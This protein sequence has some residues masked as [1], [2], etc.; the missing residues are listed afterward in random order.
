MTPYGV[1]AAL[2]ASGWFDTP[3][4]APARFHHDVAI[5]INAALQQIWNSSFGS[6]FARQEQS[7]STVNGT[8]SYGLNDGVQRVLG[9]VRC[10]GRHLIE[11]ESLAAFRDRAT[12][13]SL[14]ATET[15]PR[16]YHLQRVYVG[17]GSTDTEAM[18]LS[19]D[20]APTPTAAYTVTF[21]AQMEPPNYSACDLE[22]DSNAIPMPHRMVESLLIPLA[23]YHLRGSSYLQ[24]PKLRDAFTAD[25][26]AVLARLGLVE[27]SQA[28][29]RR[30]EVPATT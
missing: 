7:F 29:R 16:F 10:N 20:L 18:D 12:V 13:F 9:D 24:D 15:T 4:Q 23:R 11:I 19:L 1:K 3:G 28:K 30:E 6:S 8:A 2:I 14:T 5:A 27:P 17:S 25:G 22:A 21:R 26:E